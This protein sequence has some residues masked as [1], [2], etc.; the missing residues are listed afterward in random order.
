RLGEL[1]ELE[2]AANL[3]AYFWRLL[4]RVDLRAYE[5][6]A[7]SRVN[8]KALFE[9]QGELH[10]LAVDPDQ[11]DAAVFIENMKNAW[12]E[13][14]KDVLTMK[15]VRDDF[16]KITPVQ[17]TYG[18]PRADGLLDQYLK[19]PDLIAEYEQMLAEARQRRAEVIDGLKKRVEGFQ[20]RFDEYSKNIVDY[21]ERLKQMGALQADA[22]A[23][24]QKFPSTE[25][26]PKGPKEAVETLDAFLSSLD[27][28]VTRL[29]KDIDSGIYRPAADAV[30]DQ[31]LEA[32]AVTDAQLNG[33][34][35]ATLLSTHVLTSAEL[36]NGKIRIQAGLSSVKDIK[37]LTIGNGAGDEKA[38]AVKENVV[39]EF[40][41]K[42]DTDYQ[43]EIRITTA[44]G[45]TVVLPLFPQ[46]SAIRYEEINFEQKV[47]ESIQ[48]ISTSYEQ[49]DASAF[50]ELISRD[51]LGSRSVLEEGARLD[52]SAFSDIQMKI[53]INR[54][55]RRKNLYVAETQWQKMQTA[56]ASG[57]RAD[58]KGRTTLMFVYED[59]Q[60][61]IQ[62]LRGDLLYASLST[63]IAQASGLGQREVERIVR[64]RESVLSGGSV[65]SAVS[66]GAPGPG[67]ADPDPGSP[68]VEEV[69]VESGKF[70]LTQYS[71]HPMAPGTVF[72]E[73]FDFGRKQ[74]V[75]DYDI[76]VNGDFRR[77]EGWIEAGSGAGVLELS[78]SFE[79]ITEVPAGGY[80]PQAGAREGAVY[81]V[82]RADG[83][84]AIVEFQS[85]SGESVDLYEGRPISAQFRYR[86]QKNGTRTF[87]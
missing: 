80:A 12:E 43:P 51:Y 61:K 67:S 28:Y 15:K 39:Y 9:K 62:N 4:E 36:T 7:L 1:Q 29:Q 38:L 49:Q 75:K 18:D 71:A 8:I 45:K 86:Y 78:G 85:A 35:A 2:P 22:R 27:S 5:T 44:F 42:P 57:A 25:G 54:I 76:N 59:G 60:M 23:A 83:T 14:G 37:G 13:H 34:P 31:G 21:R 19:I 17:F 73:S 56:R 82:Q 55:E 53:S 79:D 40:T 69:S 33:M 26:L 41:P 24:R 65:P 87:H 50:A 16:I 68:P 48:A 77:R 11:S 74:T 32:Y 52:F 64:E 70:K 10:G 84:Y 66:E 30:P 63:E 3:A 20:G 6:A 58:T 72:A 47:V 46:T 81:A